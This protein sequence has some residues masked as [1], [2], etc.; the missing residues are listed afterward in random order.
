M[1]RNVKL[2][3]FV[4]YNEFFWGFQTLSLLYSRCSQESLLTGCLQ[5]AVGGWV[6]ETFPLTYLYC[7]FFFLGYG[8]Y[9]GDG[10]KREYDKDFRFV[11][12]RKMQFMVFKKK[13]LF[14]TM[15]VHTFFFHTE[16]SLLKWEALP[17]E[18]FTR[19]LCLSL[20]LASF[21]VI[22]EQ[23][24]EGSVTYTAK[25]FGCWCLVLGAYIRKKNYHS[26]K[27]SG[28]PCS[29]ISNVKEVQ[30]SR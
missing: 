14:V 18:T 17:H 1:I 25:H 6:G 19:L 15:R 2:G 20:T 7:S 16:G 28:E 11:C 4:K 9:Y 8:V 21:P 12:I 22:F 23:R 3:I 13:M 30:D 29:L 26:L 24:K 10:Y 27:I 5:M